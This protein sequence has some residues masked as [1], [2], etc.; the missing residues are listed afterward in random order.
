MLNITQSWI[1]FMKETSPIQKIFDQAV[2]N[3]LKTLDD[4]DVDVAELRRRLHEGS[5]PKVFKIVLDSFA[6]NA[7]EIL[8]DYKEAEASFIQGNYKK[9][10]VGFDLVEIY[11][12]ISHQIGESINTEFRPSAAKNGNFIFEATIA[13]HAR[14][15]LVSREIFWLLRG[16]FADGALGRWRTLHEISVVVVLLSE[17]DPVISQR[18]LLHRQIQNYKSMKTYVEYQEGANLTPLQDDALSKAKGAYDK[19]LDEHGEEMRYDWGWAA[20]ALSCK[21]PTFRQIE[22]HVGLDDWRP[23]YRWSSQDTHAGYRPIEAMLGTL[24]SQ[25]P[26]LLTGPSDSGLIDPAQMMAASLYTVSE[27][28]VRLAPNIDRIIYVNVLE[29]ILESIGDAFFEAE[30][31]HR[32]HDQDSEE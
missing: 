5:F 12:N 1:G 28:L 27:V 31:K 20:S 23:R 6:E 18:Y 11:L 13:L 24:E 4:R 30:E 19:I 16:G 26:F 25:Q 9:W 21:N 32:E 2:E 15:L 29:L 22:K 8:S 10:S 14:A 7:S 3:Y 17:N